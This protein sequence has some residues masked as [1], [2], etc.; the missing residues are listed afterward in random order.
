MEIIAMSV[1]ALFF[2]DARVSAPGA[3]RCQRVA[4]R[5]GSS[6]PRIER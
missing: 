6:I 4:C 2:Y 1:P 3:E 5:G